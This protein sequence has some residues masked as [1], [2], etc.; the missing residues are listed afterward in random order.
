[1][2]I[3]VE[4]ERTQ[5]MGVVKILLWLIIIAVIAAAAYYLFF[6]RPDTIP[7]LIAPAGFQ[8]TTSLSKI[9]IDPATVVQNPIF[10]SLKAHIAPMPSSTPGRANPFLPF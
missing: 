5:R 9:S 10:Q 6:K 2:A 1:M 7:N 8:N 3:V 4:Q